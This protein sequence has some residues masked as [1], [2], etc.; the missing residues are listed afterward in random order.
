MKNSCSIDLFLNSGLIRIRETS[1][2]HENAFAPS[3]YSSSSSGLEPY[4]SR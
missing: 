1:W 2:A 3:P 4:E